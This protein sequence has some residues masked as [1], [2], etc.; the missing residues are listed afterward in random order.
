VPQVRCID[1]DGNQI[2]VIQTREALAKAQ[3]VGLDLVEI[4]PTAKPPVCR[5]MDYGKYKYELGKKERAAKRNKSS[6]KVKEIKFHANTAEHDYETKVRHAREFL[7]EGHPLKVSLW[8]RG[9]EGAHRELGYQLLERVIQDIQDIGTVEQSPQMFGRNLI[10][11]L[12]PKRT[13][14]GQTKEKAKT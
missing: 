10:M 12:T 3:Q 9:R 4:S 6:S 2:G 5:I 8:F 11:R 13:G 7:E 1:P 14:K